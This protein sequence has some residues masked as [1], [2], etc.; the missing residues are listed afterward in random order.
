MTE[1]TAAA[2]RA[3]VD[4]EKY[5]ALPTVDADSKRIIRGLL[6]AVGEL[7]TLLRAEIGVSH[8]HFKYYLS[9]S[10]RCEVARGALERIA[11]GMDLRFAEAKGMAEIAREALERTERREPP[12]DKT[13][14]AGY[15]LTWGDEG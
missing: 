5:L 8:E 3:V 13:E 2:R 14:W 9:E 15:P 1:N 7:V 11:T 6:N 10:G 4:A 12:E